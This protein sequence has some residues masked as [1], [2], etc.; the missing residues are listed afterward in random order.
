MQFWAF[1]EVYKDLNP[2]PWTSRLHQPTAPFFCLTPL[3]L[4]TIRTTLLYITIIMSQFTQASTKPNHAAQVTQPPSQRTEAPANTAPT[5][6]TGRQT[7]RQRGSQGYSGNDCLALVNFVKHVLPLGSNNWDHVHELYNQY[8]LEAGR[9][10]RDPDPLKT[11][12]R[13][14]VASKKSTGNPDCPVW[15]C[16]AKRANIMI[17]DCAR[18]IAFVDEDEEEMESDDKG[19]VAYPYLL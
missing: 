17:K 1:R 15:I 7:G 9:V 8:A 10:S 13:A 12:F 14:M 19:Y 2:W 5:Q 11:K 3:C 16:E 6:T 18:S 4:H